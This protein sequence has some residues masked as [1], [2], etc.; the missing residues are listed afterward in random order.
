[1]LQQLGVAL[2]VEP[3]STNREP[4][5]AFVRACAAQL[6]LIHL[7][8]RITDLKSKLQRT[9]PVSDT[10][11][12]NQ[13]FSVLLGLE[14]DRARLKQLAV[15][16]GWAPRSAHPSPTV[17]PA[18]RSLPLVDHHVIETAPRHADLEGLP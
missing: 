5:T 13:M 18:D 1:V 4:D 16:E 3:L 9:N 2:T 7:M 8:G 15:G 17:L 14:S 11:R 6:R 10:A 12:Y